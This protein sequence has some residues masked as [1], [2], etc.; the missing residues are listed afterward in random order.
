MRNKRHSS[1]E[2]NEKRR[3]SNLGKRRSPETCRNI[4]KSQQDGHGHFQGHH[5]SVATK[6]KIRQAFL[7]R[8]VSAATREKL[9]QASWKGGISFLPYP[10][11]WT[12]DLREAIRKRDKYTCQVCSTGQEDLSKK[13][14]IHHIDYDKKNLD[15][16]N[17]ISLCHPCHMKTN[18]H[19]KIWK[20][21]FQLK[22]CGTGCMPMVDGLVWDQAAAG[23]NPATQ[24][25]DQS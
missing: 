24:N 7:G 16:E 3:R 25:G 10:T 15:P 5:H 2:S 19:R 22:Q 18:Q 20:D 23:S 8:S 6:E 9:R 14:D 4:S 21:F 1:P 11:F 12:E 17:L 13:L